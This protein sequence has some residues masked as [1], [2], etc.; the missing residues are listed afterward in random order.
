MRDVLFTFV[1]LTLS[2]GSVLG[3]QTK[4]D[5]PSVTLPPELARVLTDYEAGWTA[6]D[7][8]ALARLFAE[9]GFV[10]PGG[11]P[12]VKGRAAIEKLYTGKGAPLS[13]RAFAYAMHG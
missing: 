12:P 13:L 7:A 5:E 8:A 11:Q 10:L 4:S 9:D 1:L 2:A 3:Q 6:G